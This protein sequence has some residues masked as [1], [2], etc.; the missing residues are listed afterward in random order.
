MVANML[1]YLKSTVAVAAVLGTV[2]LTPAQAQSAAELALRMSQL[3]EQVRALTGQVEQLTFE[4]KRIKSAKAP[5]S[6]EENVLPFKKKTASASSDVIESQ[7]LEPLTEGSEQIL[8][9]P[10]KLKSGGWRG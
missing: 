10:K 4:I 8:E 3:E 9:L 7:P 5:G 2:M 6:E 1:K